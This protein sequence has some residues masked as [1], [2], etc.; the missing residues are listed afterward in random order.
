MS[1]LGSPN[2]PRVFGNIYQLLTAPPAYNEPE[3][4]VD[5]VTALVSA[6]A[7][8]CLQST[9]DQEKIPALIAQNR[10]VSA[11]EFFLTNDTDVALRTFGGLEALQSLAL[12][13]RERFSLL[14][15][16]EVPFPSLTSLTVSN[17]YISNIVML[18]ISKLSLKSLS[19]RNCKLDCPCLLTSLEKC[20]NLGLI[21][22]EGTVI[23]NE[24]VNTMLGQ[25]HLLSK[26]LPN[27]TIVPKDS[28]CTYTDYS[29]VLCTE[30]VGSCCSSFEELQKPI[31][32]K[33]LYK[34]LQLGIEE[35]NHW[36][37]WGDSVN[38]V[39]VHNRCQLLPKASPIHCPDGR[40]R[41]AMSLPDDNAE[42][43]WR[44]VDAKKVRVIVSVMDFAND[45]IPTKKRPRDFGRGNLLVE[46]VKEEYDEAMGRDLR[47]LTVH[48]ETVYHL[49]LH[50]RG[51]EGI[52]IERLAPFLQEV[53]RL[54]NA[55]PG[56]TI[57]HCE[58]GVGRTG[59]FFACMILWQ[60]WQR[61]DK[62]HKLY[63][64]LEVLLLA[65]RQQRPCMIETVEQ[66]ETARLFLAHL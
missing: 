65:L 16:A 43:F 54:E 55:N 13:G 17:A 12:H 3:P 33:D 59:T 30:K 7:F 2:L 21:N 62:S 46:C 42:R 51:L 63:F 5:S 34:L 14:V 61:L 45:Y 49:Q 56:Q 20:T 22:L 18:A 36:E 4:D 15:G 31:P 38:N 58:Q 40:E 24:P 44:Y 41:F 35:E 25:I 29:K 60:L 32:E 1:L 26:L 6:L 27:A 28:I 10:S 37:I 39:Y 9:I 52:E 66:L 19:L 47:E 64:N 11:I 50:W 48:G 57:V 23:R 8:P 53:M